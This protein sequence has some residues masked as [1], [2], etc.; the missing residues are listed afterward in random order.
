M[1]KKRRLMS[2]KAKFNA[3]HSDHPRMKHLDSV[4]A[5]A[6]DTPAE[7]PP[8]VL[9]QEVEAAPQEENAQAKQKATPKRKGTKKETTKRRKTTKKTAQSAIT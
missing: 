4:G 1:G 2:A 8:E 6:E 9:L 3:K 5:N 7:P